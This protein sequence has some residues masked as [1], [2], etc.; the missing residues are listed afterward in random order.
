MNL[1]NYTFKQS[2]NNALMLA[3]SKSFI[4]LL[5]IIALAFCLRTYKLQEVPAGL[6]I[7]EISGLY[8]PFLYIHGIVDLSLRGAI[9]YFLSGTFFIYFLA[10]SSSLFA[11]LSEDVFGTLLVFV[12]YLLAK[13]MFSKKVGL[14]SA[15]LIALCPWAVHFSRFQAYSSS[16]VLFFTTALMFVYKGINCDNRRKKFIW[17]CLGSLTFGLTADIFASSSVFV[18]VFITIFLFI[19]L[20]KKIKRQTIHSISP[21]GI[22]WPL[23]IVLM[24]VLSYSPIFLIFGHRDG[25]AFFAQSYSTY[26]HSRNFVDWFR[27]IIDRAGVHLSPGFI[28]FAFPDTHDLPFQQTISKSALLRYSPTQYGELNYYGILLYPGIFLLVYQWISKGS[29]K[30]AVILWW[31][32]C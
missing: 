2:V 21:K 32:V 19:Y 24:F 28:V 5:L 22:F 20:Q 23:V 31:I 11:R 6:F 4:L 17:Y 18:P 26:S 12:V 13:E 9:S 1:G 7:D 29:K 30:H 15:L 27:M 25:Y 10:G 14:I 8:T 3:R 16:Y